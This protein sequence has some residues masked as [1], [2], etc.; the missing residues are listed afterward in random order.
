MPLIIPRNTYSAGMMRERRGLTAAVQGGVGISALED[1]DLLTIDR[2]DLV[3]KIL[4]VLLRGNHP[5]PPLFHDDEVVALRTLPPR[6]PSRPWCVQAVGFVIDPT[7][8]AP[9]NP[10]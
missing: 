7:P 6:S 10:V 8:A 5:L 1:F 3:E 2:L 4:C 9:G